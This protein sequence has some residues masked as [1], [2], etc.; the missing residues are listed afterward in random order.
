MENKLDSHA[1][2]VDGR[3]RNLEYT[4][5]SVANDLQRIDRTIGDLERASE[6]RGRQTTELE[7]Q[8][9]LAK[10]RLDGLY[11]Q[12]DALKINVDDLHVRWNNTKSRHVRD[13]AESGIPLQWIYLFVVGIT[14]GAII[15]AALGFY[16]RNG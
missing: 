14:L 15:V 12:L 11:T 16:L 8:L 5:N 6:L 3:F 9:A 4:T 1:M 13:V 7:H 10:G 2:Q